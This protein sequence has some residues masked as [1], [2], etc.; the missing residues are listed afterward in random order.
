MIQLD[1]NVLTR[2]TRSQDP[3]SAVARAAVQTLRGRGGRL[4]IVPQNLCECWAT[5]TRPPG[6]PPAGSNGLG[7]TSAQAGQ[8]LRFFQRWCTLL[9]DRVE[10]PVLWQ[11]LVEAHS[12]TGFR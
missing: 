4:I 11:V 1:T 12:V 3:Q 10:L 8:W 9:P 5:G 2:V 6:P 7:M